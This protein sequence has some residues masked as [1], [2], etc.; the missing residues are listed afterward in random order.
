M[1]KAG[2]GVIVI[3]DAETSWDGIKPV[4]VK[5]GEI[6]T[7]RVKCAH[8]LKKKLARMHKPKKPSGAVTGAI[9]PV[10]QR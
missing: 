3:K 10:T 1:S 6:F 2:V 9:D 5:K 4:S 8:L 7:D